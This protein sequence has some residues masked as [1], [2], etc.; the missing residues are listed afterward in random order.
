MEGCRTARS[1]RSG[2][3]YPNRSNDTLGQTNVHRRQVLDPGR[4]LSMF[5]LPS[6]R[7]KLVVLAWATVVLGPTGFTI[8]ASGRRFGPLP[9]RSLRRRAMG[10]IPRMN[11]QL[12]LVSSLFLTWC[13][14]QVT[15]YASTRYRIKRE[16]R[17]VLCDHPFPHDFLVHITR[18]LLPD[19]RALT[20][21]STSN[22]QCRIIRL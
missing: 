5:P 1:I 2:W 12:R 17:V 10:W 22:R 15:S 9:C 8:T 6:T 16:A 21:Q 7:R 13:D 4:R 11:Y 19:P 3:L 14:I 18:P 20:L